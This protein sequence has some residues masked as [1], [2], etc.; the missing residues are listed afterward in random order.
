MPPTT[1]VGTAL[2]LACPLW[3]KSRHLRARQRC[4]LYPQNRT[5]DDIGRHFETRALPTPARFFTVSRFLIAPTADVRAR[6]RGQCVI[7]ANVRYRFPPS[8]HRGC[9][10][11]NRCGVP[12]GITLA[13]QRK[14]VMEISELFPS[15]EAI[16]AT[17]GALNGELDDK[18]FCGASAAPHQRQCRSE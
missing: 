1:P 4:P 8:D 5:F 15:D 14:H 2:T 11:R 17:N 10:L 12:L 7:T 3:V 13:S 9:S 16:I 6:A 18:A